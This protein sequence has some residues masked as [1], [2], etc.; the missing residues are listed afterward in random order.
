MLKR[1]LVKGVGWY[2][3]ELY[4]SLES[5]SAFQFWMSLA[6]PS[7]KHFKFFFPISA[8]GGCFLTAV[9]WHGALGL[10]HSMNINNSQLAMSA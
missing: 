1:T 4:L 2:G 5:Y 7:N 10:S 6:A 8:W 3:F 9:C